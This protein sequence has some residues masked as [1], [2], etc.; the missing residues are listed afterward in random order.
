MKRPIPQG[1]GLFIWAFDAADLRRL[2]QHARIARTHLRAALPRASKVVLTGVR[3]LVAADTHLLAAASKLRGSQSRT[4]PPLSRSPPKS[5]DTHLP[6]TRVGDVAA[7]VG[8]RPTMP[9]RHFCYRSRP[10]RAR[11]WFLCRQNP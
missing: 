4:P 3:G 2:R 5:A 1:V 8:H 7:K 6:A 10:S 11:N 9:W